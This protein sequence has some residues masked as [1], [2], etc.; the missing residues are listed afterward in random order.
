MFIFEFIIKRI[1]YIF[2]YFGTLRIYNQAANDRYPSSSGSLKQVS[3]SILS[4]AL[5]ISLLYLNISLKIRFWPYI[6]D[7]RQNGSAQDVGRQEDLQLNNSKYVA[8]INKLIF[9]KSYKSIRTAS[10]NLKIFISSFVPF[11]I[12]LVFN[13]QI[14]I[15]LNFYCNGY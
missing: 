9:R 14:S 4:S 15:Y 3:L 12:N 5:N 6:F 13:S 1:K 11:K 7:H 8:G 2:V 10:N